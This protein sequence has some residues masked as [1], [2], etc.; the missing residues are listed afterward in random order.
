[1]LVVG[2]GNDVVVD[3]GSVVDVAAAVVDG[4][5]AVVG[6]TVVLAT[7]AA[8]LDESSEPAANT[9]AVTPATSASIAAET[10]A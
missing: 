10:S 2:V 8:G 4:A 7:G 6:A 5:S 1:M 9:A 3:G